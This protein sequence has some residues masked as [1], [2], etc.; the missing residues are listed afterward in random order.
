MLPFVVQGEHSVWLQKQSGVPKPQTGPGETGWLSVWFAFGLLILR[1][2]THSRGGVLGEE[3]EKERQEKGGDEC[4]VKVLMFWKKYFNIF[5]SFTHKHSQSACP[6]L[7]EFHSIS[8]IACLYL[9]N[10]LSGLRALLISGGLDWLLSAEH[11]QWE[12]RMSGELENV[13]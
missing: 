5:L 13:D 2:F 1:H 7:W 4:Q 3:E 6:Q 12:E 10:A 9:R 11:T 8:V